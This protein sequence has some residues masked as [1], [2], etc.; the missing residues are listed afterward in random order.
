MKYKFFVIILFFSLLF[1]ANLNANIVPT[2]QAQNPPFNVQLPCGNADVNNDN[3]VNT[4]D[5]LLVTNHI[6]QSNS[7][8]DV[9]LDG[10]VNIEDVIFTS[11]CVG[12]VLDSPPPNPPF[13]LQLPCGQAD[14]NEDNTVNTQD[15]L[16]VVNHIGET[17]PGQIQIYDVDVDGDVDIDDI[18][19]VSNCVGVT[20][21]I[22]RNPCEGGVCETALGPISTNITQFAAKF[23]TIAIGLAGGIALILLVYGSVRVLTSAGNQ[24]SLAAGRDVIIAAIAGLL[25]LIFSI[26]ILRALGLVIGLPFG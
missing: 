1:S 3:V 2:V 14:V 11:N 13:N 7:D 8:F 24:Q 15:V 20:I 22:G 12:I 18:N 9:N 21:N 10:I 25:F 23:L 4:A 6:G 17:N 26:L 16:L 19:Y 5:V